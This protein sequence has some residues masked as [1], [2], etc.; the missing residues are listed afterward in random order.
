V[1]ITEGLRSDGRWSL[2]LALHEAPLLPVFA[3]LCRDIVAHT[4]SGVEPAQLSAVILRRIDRWRNL[5]A[6]D[7]GGLAESVLRGLIGELL[8]LEF[9]L[10]P[11]LSERQ[12]VAAWT[13]PSGSPQDF[14]LPS[15]QHLEVKTIARDA[16]SV[17]ING[18]GQLDAGKDP[19]FLILVRAEVTGPSAPG[20]VTAPSLVARIRTRLSSDPD[21]LAEFDAVLASFGWHE[22]PSHETVALRPLAI[23]EHEVGGQFPRLTGTNVPS[24]VQDAVYVVSVPTGGTAVWRA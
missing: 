23:E 16:G 24:G 4:R 10:L 13:G 14:V 18:L 3:A 15:G 20:S 17:Q 7:S 6:R 9:K 1:E 19:L 2:R 11:I 8:V 21:A 22:D 5:L 12:A